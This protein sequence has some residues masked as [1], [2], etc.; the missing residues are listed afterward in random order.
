MTSRLTAAGWA[1]LAVAFLLLL[2]GADARAVTAATRLV[3]LDTADEAF[4]QAGIMLAAYVTQYLVLGGLFEG[5]HPEG[6]VRTADPARRARRAAQVAAEVRSGLLSLAVT[7]GLAV[8]Y[9]ALLEP[10]TPFYGFFETHEWSWAWALGGA[11]AYV[12]AFDTHFYWSHWLL[13]EVEWAWHNI[14]YFHHGYKEPSAFAQFAVHPVEAAIQGPFGHF[15]VQLIF[16]VHPIQLAIMGFLSSAYAFAAHDGRLQAMTNFHWFHHTKGRG[17]KHYFNLGFLT[18]AWDVVMGTRWHPQHP[19]WLEWENRRAAAGLAD[20]R[21]GTAAGIKNDVFGADL[22]G[23][24]APAQ[25]AARG[26]SKRKAA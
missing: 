12:A 21:D 13:H 15:A 19:L 6:S 25:K 22:D 10:R 5:T 11:V 24:K 9:M 26:G 8:A 14:H 2:A 4:V 20:T 7:V 3:A 17:R 16:P 23:D 18:P 1:L